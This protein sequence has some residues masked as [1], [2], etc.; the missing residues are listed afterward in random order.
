MS[1]GQVLRLRVRHL[2]DGVF[3]GSPEF[4]NDLF[5]RRRDRFGARRK[6]GARPIRGVTLPGIQAL[7]DLRDKVPGSKFW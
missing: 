1:L 7:R 2:T 3:L 4:V 6:D 5:T